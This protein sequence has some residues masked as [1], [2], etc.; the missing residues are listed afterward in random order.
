MT[1]IAR[2]SALSAA[3]WSRDSKRSLSFQ[4]CSMKPVAAMFKPSFS[5]PTPEDSY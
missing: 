3:H 2:L 5:S 4:V 1:N